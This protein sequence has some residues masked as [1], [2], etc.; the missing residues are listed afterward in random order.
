MANE[1]KA[2]A[3]KVAKSVKRIALRKALSERIKAKGLAIGADAVYEDECFIVDLK[4]YRRY[5]SIN[6][7]GGS[8]SL[9]LQLTFKTIGTFG[10]RTL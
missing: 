2:A 1:L 10:Y 4:Y 3:K 8:Q 7:D 9:L 6:N 5:T